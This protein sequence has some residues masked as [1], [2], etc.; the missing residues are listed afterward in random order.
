M[1]KIASPQQLQAEIKAI[2]AFI[3]SSEKP[4]RQVV[5]SKLRELADRVGGHTV[6]AFEGPKWLQRMLKR[7]KFTFS[8]GTY[9]IE[10]GDREADANRLEDKI[11]AEANRN[12]SSDE[13]FEVEAWGTQDPKTGKYTV[14]IQ[15]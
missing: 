3:H 12:K 8:K 4:D 11:N 6:V 14:N 10:T 7:H 13:D 2:M 9:K 15:V 5:A 1:Q